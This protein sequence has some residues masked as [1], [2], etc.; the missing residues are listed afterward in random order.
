MATIRPPAIPM[1]VNSCRNRLPR[2]PLFDLSGARGEEKMDDDVRKPR[3]VAS[4]KPQLV[5]STIAIR[6]EVSVED[7]SSA[8]PKAWRSPAP[9]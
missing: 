8:P 3:L 7:P 1:S 9:T 6:C 2:Y 5:A 4:I